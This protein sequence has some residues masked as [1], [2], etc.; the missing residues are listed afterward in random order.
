MAVK[1]FVLGSPGS[2]KSTVCRYIV[3][4][5]REQYQ[6]LSAKHINDY[7]ILY[8]MFRDYKDDS[9]QKRFIA[10]A[11]DG[12]VVLDP[13]VYNDALKDVEREIDVLEQVH[14]VVAEF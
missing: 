13:T 14:V 2:G 5:I 11:H 1:L 12:F 10:T 9:E 8:Q 7:D 4:Y 6:D 3:K